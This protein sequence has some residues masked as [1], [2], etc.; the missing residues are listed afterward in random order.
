MADEATLYDVQ[1]GIAHITLNEP[2][3]RNAL[4]TTLVASL[5]A[6]FD[7]A[8]DDDGVR[9][10]L[11]TNAGGRVFCAGADLKARSS[12]D[13]QEESGGTSFADLLVGLRECPKPTVARIDGHCA[14]GGVGLAAAFDISIARD[15]AT[16][17]FT[18]VR[19]GVAP[20][21]ISLVCLPKMRDADARELMLRGNRFDAT[22]AARVGLITRAVPT[23]DLDTEVDAVLDDL[24]RG[25]PS[26]LATVKELIAKVP[27]MPLDDAKAWTSELSASLFD[28][29]EGQAGMKAFLAKE[30]APWV[31]ES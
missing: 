12:D 24:S 22:E 19:L 15:N 3:N 6:D 10:V 9:A 5:L 7:R 4:S 17:G 20:A 23:D 18:E 25:G 30:D 26:A 2:D 31:P 28:A 11:V 8:L 29:E 14:G 16:F 27:A 13:G 21:V 1:R